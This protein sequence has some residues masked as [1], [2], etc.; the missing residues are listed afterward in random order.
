MLEGDPA[1]EARAQLSPDEA[2]RC[3]QEGRSMEL[4][5]ALALAGRGAAD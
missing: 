2:E 4:E 1:A 5:Q 3:W